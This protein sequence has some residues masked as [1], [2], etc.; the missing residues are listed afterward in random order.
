MRYLNAITAKRN[1]PLPVPAGGGILLVGVASGFS[2]FNYSYG[3][4]LPPAGHAAD[5]DGRRNCSVRHSSPPCG[6]GRVDYGSTFFVLDQRI[7]D[8]H[9]QHLA[10]SC[11]WLR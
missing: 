2:F 9:F 5:F 1:P 7:C 6:D 11:R 8:S 3:V 4:A 10:N